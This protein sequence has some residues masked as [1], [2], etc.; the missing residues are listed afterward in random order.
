MSLRGFVREDEDVPVV[1]V[2]PVLGDDEFDD[3]DDDDE[4]MHSTCSSRIDSAGSDSN[5]R[6]SYIHPH[7]DRIRESHKIRD[8]NQDTPQRV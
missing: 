7:S 6:S 5:R 3:D 1:P 4:F 8:D 2:P